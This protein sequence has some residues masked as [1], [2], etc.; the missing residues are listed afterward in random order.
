MRNINMN[1]CF[2]MC[3]EWVKKCKVALNQVRAK[4]KAAYLPNNPQKL[5]QQFFFSSSSSPSSE[6]ETMGSI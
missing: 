5:V 2:M 3:K 1:Y 4:D 6:S